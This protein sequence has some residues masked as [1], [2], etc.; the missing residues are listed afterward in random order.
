MTQ[1]RKINR[2]EYL[3]ALALFVCANDHYVRSRRFEEQM[4]RV[5]GVK[6][7]RHYCGLVSDALYVDEPATAH[8]FD[9]ALKDSGI[10]VEDGP[11][12]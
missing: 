9:T 6:D 7:D 11:Q 1:K 3:R 12:D 4:A 8:D 10:E 5:L 2:D